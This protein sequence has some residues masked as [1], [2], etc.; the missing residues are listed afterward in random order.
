[1]FSANG[2]LLKRGYIGILL[3]SLMLGAACATE[4]GSF[5]E[6]NPEVVPKN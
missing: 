3:L 2:V 1:M 5:E 4:V 6:R